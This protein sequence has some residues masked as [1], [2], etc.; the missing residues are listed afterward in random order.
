MARPARSG[1]RAQLS[2][3]TATPPDKT[4]ESHNDAGWSTVGDIGYVDED[5]Y[6]YISDR[7][8]DMIIRGGV[9]VY[10]RE[11]E[12]A[13]IAHPKVAD[14]AV[15][16]IPD[17]DLGEAVHAV[18]VPAGDAAAG[19]GLSDELLAYLHERLAKYKCPEAIEFATELPRHATGKLYKRLLK[20]SYRQDV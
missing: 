10:P 13:L 8:A 6:L 3:S 9:N 16:G 17:D 15:F 18:V 11:A 12:D 19:P 7:R 1:R 2:S 14:A 5:G 4:A 20:D